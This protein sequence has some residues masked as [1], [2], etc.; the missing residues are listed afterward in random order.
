MVAPHCYVP[1]KMMAKPEKQERLL[2]LLVG[3]LTTRNVGF[4]HKP[5]TY[6]YTYIYIRAS[7]LTWAIPKSPWVYILTWS[8]SRWFW[9][10]HILGHL[11]KISNSCHHFS[12]F[13]QPRG[14]KKRKKNAYMTAP[15]FLIVHQQNNKQNTWGCSSSYTLDYNLNWSQL[16]DV[17]RV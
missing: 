3:D 4:S 13:C 16:L 17:F 7:C 1:Q 8:N 11:P 9:G 12:I 10:T 15:H 6:I 2:C 14:I 5:P